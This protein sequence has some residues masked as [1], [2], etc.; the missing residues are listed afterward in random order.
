MS[1]WSGRRQNLVMLLNL[2]RKLAGIAIIDLQVYND[3]GAKLDKYHRREH[4]R[5]G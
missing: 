2:S 5:S 4:G 3:T 1:T